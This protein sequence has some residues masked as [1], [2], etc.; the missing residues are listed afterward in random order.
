MFKFVY[1]RTNKLQ[2][3]LHVLDL[4]QTIDDFLPAGLL[5]ENL[6]W[7]KSVFK[8]YK[9]RS[10]EFTQKGFFINSDAINLVSIV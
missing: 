3:Y 1:Q 9:L 7:G 5:R 6:T 2:N 8:S 10:Y 4:G